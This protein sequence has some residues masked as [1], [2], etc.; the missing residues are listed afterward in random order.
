M[1]KYIKSKKYDGVQHYIKA[2]GTK[3]YYVRY[4]DEYGM[5]QAIDVAIKMQEFIEWYKKEHKNI[6]PV[7]LAARVHVYFVGIHPFID[8]NGRTSRLLMNLELIKHGY[9]PAIIKVEDK[10]QYYKAL[11]TAHTTQNYEPFFELI[12]KVVQESF[13]PYFYVLGID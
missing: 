11:D 9:P 12:S 6:H 4:K 7:E 5:A 3:S 2:D 10:L 1:S 8:G 13:E